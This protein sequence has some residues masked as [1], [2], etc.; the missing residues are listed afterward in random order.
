MFAVLPPIRKAL[1]P[2]IGLVAA[3]MLAACDPTAMTGMGGGG[4]SGPKIDPAKPIQVA[5]L[6]PKSDPAA[7]PVALSLEQAAR[8]AISELKGATIDLRVYDTAGAPATA[9][10]QAQRAIDDGAKIILGPLRAESVNEA[11]RA[12]ADDS[13]NVLGF[14]NN[15]SIAGGN[16]FILGPTFNNTA[17]RLMAHA[18]SQGKKSIVIVYSNDVPG[19]FGR[20]AIELAASANGIRVVSAEGYSLSVEGVTATAQAAAAAVQ[21]GAA[22]TIFITTDA[23]NA[24]MP[25]LLN[26]LPSNGI[27]PDQVQY[28]GLTRLDVRPDLFSLPGANGAWFALPDQ[29]RQNA[30]N[31]RYSAAFGSAPHPLAGL[32]YD[33]LSAIGALAG[34]GRGDALTAKALTRG[35]GF[36]GTGGVFRLKADG[37][38]ERALSVATIKDN[39]MVILDPA[40]SSF[41]GAGF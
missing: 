39:Q 32:A 23:T 26:Q 17:N 31:Q 2:A 10:A 9:A 18:R 33:G 29:T 27:A 8:L 38:N 7:G 12:A 16:V 5:L 36:T 1:R 15:P 4:N 34:Q 35:T 11:G 28:V 6:V 14:S 40:P 21:S 37:T 41:S 30:F 3:L 13:V 22:D 19:Q 25:M 20:S 24:A